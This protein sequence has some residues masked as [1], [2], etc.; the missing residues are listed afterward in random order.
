MVVQIVATNLDIPI[1]IVNNI[2][3]LVEGGATIPFIARYRKEMTG[4]LNEEKLREVVDEIEKTKALLA[5]KS[6]ILNSLRKRQ[7]LTSELE[8]LIESCTTMSELEAIYSPFKSSKKTLA[9]KARECGIDKLTEQLLDSPQ[10]TL[11]K[12]V[13]FSKDSGIPVE[14]LEEGIVHLIAEKMATNGPTR[15]EIVNTIRKEGFL[16][17]K[18]IPEEKRKAK[19]GYEGQETKESKLVEEEQKISLRRIKPHQIQAFKK[20]ENRGQIKINWE[21]PDEQIKAKLIHS[22]ENKIGKVDPNLKSLLVRSSESSYRRLIKPS[23]SRQV[24]KELVEEAEKHAIKIFTHNLRNLLMQP[25]LKGKIILGLDPGLRTGTK[26]AVIDKKGDVLHVGTVFTLNPERG[27]IQ[28]KEILVKHKVEYIALGNGTGSREVEE[29]VQQIIDGTKCQYAIVSEAGASVYSASEIAKEEFPDFD[30]SLRGAISIARRLQDPLAEL[31]KIDPRS[32]GIGQYQHD[33]D[34]TRLKDALEKTMEDVVNLIGVDVNTASWPLLSYVSGLS[35]STAKNIVEVRKNRRFTSRDEIAKVKGIGPKTFEQAI[36][37][38]RIYNGENPLDAT[39]IHPE[40]YNIVVRLLESMERQLSDLTEDHQSLKKD[41]ENM[42]AEYL[43]SFSSSF[44]VGLPTL[45][46]IV[47]SLKNPTKDPR[48]EFEKD[49]FDQKIRSIDD[50]EPEMILKGVVR[51]VT[52]FGAFIDIG[53]KRDALVHISQMADRFVRHP[54]E[55]VKVGE[56]V[57]VRILSVDKG[58]IS[59]SLKGSTELPKEN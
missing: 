52:D 6:S 3:E 22:M 8:N 13:K 27:K 28:L 53:V 36:G 39:P 5:R 50:L 4:S 10:G 16:S 29:I 15:T 46:D 56:K 17:N 11:E 49:E 25:P 34:Q 31:V 19:K 1:E 57:T 51:N 35:K 12:I 55:V 54:S 37:F 44:N 42:S 7:I 40:S 32:L 30:V 20:A 33:V 24:Y 41:L 26:A 23:I 38:L 21:F 47:E 18:I 59:A 43:S 9:Q 2:L 45:R 14:E 58:R 48:G